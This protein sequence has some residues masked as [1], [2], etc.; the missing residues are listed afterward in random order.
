MTTT[1]RNENKIMNYMID[2]L[3][4]AGW[5]LHA[6]DDGEELIKT[7]NKEIALEY[8]NDLDEVHFIFKK[9]GHTC[10]AFLIF[11]NGNYGLDVIA[12]HSDDKWGFSNIM[13]DVQN[14]IENSQETTLP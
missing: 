7:S 12:D 10:S 6:L 4:E 1:I 5:K 8:A 3:M 14:W 13:D 2:R 9:E 11:G